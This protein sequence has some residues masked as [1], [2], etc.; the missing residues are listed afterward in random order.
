MSKELLEIN[1]EAFLKLDL[2]MS[3]KI[4]EITL[5]DLSTAISWWQVKAK[6]IE[7]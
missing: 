2:E 1:I 3:L 5:S 4:V 7:G 6:I